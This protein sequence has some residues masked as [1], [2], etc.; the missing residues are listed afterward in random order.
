MAWKILSAIISLCLGTASY[1]AW[2]NSK[3]LEE[4]KKMEARA[5][6]NLEQAGKRKEEMALAE[7]AKT[8]QLA[9]AEQ[10]RDTTKGEVV[11]AVAETQEKEASLALVKTNL[12]EVTKQ[13]DTLQKKVDEAGDI[14]KLIA[15]VDA[16]KKDQ[17]A[18]EGKL[19]NRSQQLAVT[20]EQLASLNEQIKK[21][22]EA[23]ARA[24]RG[25]VEPDF[26]AR[27]AQVF[28][29]WGFVVLSKG[30]AGGV[31]A[32]ATLDVKRGS[33]IVAKLKVK[34]V[35][36]SISVCD[37]VPGSLAEGDTIRSGDLVVAAAEAAA[38]AEAP[39]TQDAGGVA[40]TPA[41]PAGGGMSSDPFGSAPAG[42]ATPAPAMGGDPFGSAPA[43]PAPAPAMGGDPFGAAPAAPA[44]GTPA[45]STADPFK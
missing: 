22:E 30:N 6:A 4:E 21:F 31:F 17:L 11:K 5:I 42:G 36:Q 32:K 41:P 18:A 29:D 15:Q 34:N 8:D 10:E 45:P 25:V 44:G 3:A 19:A 20:Q 14:K 2:S 35:E 39:K 12:D 7:K 26:T 43:A 37:V 33:D 1:F 40:P 27:V 13:V 38:P 28:P 23:Q 9:A 24:T 16:L